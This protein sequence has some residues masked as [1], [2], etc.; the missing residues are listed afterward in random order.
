MAW[1]R[2]STA[3]STRGA[4]GARACFCVQRC[5]CALASL[6]RRCPGRAARRT[7]QRAAL[8][9]RMVWLRA[10]CR[11]VADAA[12]W[13]PRTG[14][15]KG[16]LGAWAHSVWLRRARAVRKEGGSTRAVGATWRP[17]APARALLSNEAPHAPI[18]E[19]CRLTRPPA[20]ACA[21][22]K[23]AIGQGEVRCGRSR[24]HPARRAADVRAARSF[25]S[26]KSGEES[27]GYAQAFWRHL[28]CVTAKVASNVAAKGIEVEVID[29]RC[30]AA[31]GKALGFADASGFSCAGL[32]GAAGE[33]PEGGARRVRDRAGAC[34]SSALARACTAC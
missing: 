13:R 14:R 25:A 28:E 3:W 11:G 9:A 29:V 17:H 34:C 15:C 7:R 30:V 26:I 10:A 27:V 16:R 4:D 2:P 31:R 22:C 20:P 21:A 8:R 18:P 12:S 6:C 23:E 1:R 32:R 33:G 24:L 5:A 19:R